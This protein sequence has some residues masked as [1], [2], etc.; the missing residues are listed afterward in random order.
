MHPCNSLHSVKGGT[1]GA[2]G[3]DI[4][5]DA[6]SP[7]ITPKM[8]SHFSGPDMATTTIPP[9]FHAVPLLYKKGTFA[10]CFFLPDSFYSFIYLN[11]RKL[12]LRRRPQQGLFRAISLLVQRFSEIFYA[13]FF[14]DS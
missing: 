6:P 14:I 12:S 9:A 8:L 11:T 7:S 2:G 13:P 5:A 1:G 4:G 10:P 3:V